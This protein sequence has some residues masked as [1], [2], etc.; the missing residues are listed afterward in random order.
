MT[1][2][3]EVSS[4]TL[5]VA[6]LWTS[7]LTVSSQVWT[8]GPGVPCLHT[9]QT[10]FP[11]Y[12][13]RS[14][15]T[16]VTQ[17]AVC[18]LVEDSR[19][20]CAVC[21]TGLIDVSS[22]IQNTLP[23]VTGAITGITVFDTTEQGLINQV[24]ADLVGIEQFGNMANILNNEDDLIGPNICTW[25]QTFATKLWRIKDNIERFLGLVDDRGGI[26]GENER[27]AL[28][29][30]IDLVHWFKQCFLPRLLELSGLECFK[31]DLG[32][33]GRPFCKSD[34]RCSECRDDNDCNEPSRPN[35]RNNLAG[36]MIC[37]DP[38]ISQTIKG[39]DHRRLCY[40]FVGKPGSAYLFF[41]DHE[42]DIKTTFIEN[43]DAIHESFVDYIGHINVTRKGIDISISPDE[44][45]LRTSECETI[46]PWKED[47][48]K[49]EGELMMIGKKQIHVYFNNDTVELVVTRKGRAKGTTFLNF[50]VTEKTGQSIYAG[51]VMG[52]IGNEAVYKDEGPHSGYITLGEVTIPVYDN[53]DGCLRIDEAYLDKFSSILHLFEM[54]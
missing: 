41:R 2:I 32:C 5:I 52:W 48:V 35:C 12:Q 6:V 13:C 4:I 17:N 27:E 40:D 38:H 7:P 15:S 20:C 45:I 29:T 30:V 19:G 37:G 46:Y 49:L 24:L 16:P 50:G 44:V 25:G 51:G 54:D 28:Q 1:L 8:I 22:N 18:S 34:C 39:A 26:V 43:E 3:M 47:T 42:I 11:L 36:I 53:K 31:D 23:S 9:C 14:I 21:V 10:I 33:D